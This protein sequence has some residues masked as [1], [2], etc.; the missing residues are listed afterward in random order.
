MVTEKLKYYKLENFSM[1]NKTYSFAD[2][3]YK[4]Y[5]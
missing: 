4:A 1:K 3:V 2:D 5:S